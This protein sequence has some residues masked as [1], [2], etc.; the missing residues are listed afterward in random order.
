MTD[1]QYVHYSADFRILGSNQD[2]QMK[3]A[4]VSHS[5]STTILTSDVKVWFR[6]NKPNQTKPN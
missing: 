6:T 2:I 1:L 3:L 5:V 4:K